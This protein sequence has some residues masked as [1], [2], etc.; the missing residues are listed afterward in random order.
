MSA[1]VADMRAKYYCH[2]SRYLAVPK[3][4]FMKKICYVHEQCHADVDGYVKPL[5]YVLLY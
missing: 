4:L 5:Q 3:N 2:S 1:L